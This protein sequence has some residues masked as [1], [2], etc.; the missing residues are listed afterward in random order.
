M[1]AM[2]LEFK[3][4]TF[5]SVQDFAL[6]LQNAA[7]MGP[8][9][10]EQTIQ[11]AAEIYYNELFNL[12]EV[13]H[14]SWPPHSSAW[15]D[16]KIRK[17]GRSGFYRFQDEFISSIKMEWID[18]SQSRKAMFVGVQ[19]DTPHSGGITT[20]DLAIVLEEKY[21]RPLFDPAYQR[22]KDDIKKHLENIAAE[23]IE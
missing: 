6:K 19:S 5:G 11:E 10:I 18:N 12:I 8:F 23:L 21:N 22:V 15:V 3:I 7:D 4:H 1:S 2:Q 16:Q 20:G 14:S 17:G 13:G 9:K